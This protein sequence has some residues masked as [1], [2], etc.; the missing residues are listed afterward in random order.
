L[1]RRR[2]YLSETGCLVQI[3]LICARSAR[4]SPRWPAAPIGGSSR[5]GVGA[6]PV[7][8]PMFGDPPGPARWPGERRAVRA[9]PLSV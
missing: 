8:A 4:R 7:T 2:Q 5:L 6:P 1:C 9:A 3:A